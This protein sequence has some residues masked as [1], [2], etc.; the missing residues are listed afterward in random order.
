MEFFYAWNQLRALKYHETAL[1]NSKNTIFK[2]KKPY[3]CDFLAV[4]FY[5]F[6]I[7]AIDFH[8]KAPYRTVLKKKFSA[9]I[10]LKNPIFLVHIVELYLDVEKRATK[11]LAPAME[12]RQLKAG[13]ILARMKNDKTIKIA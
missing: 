6:C 10:C 3:F 2:S 9:K 12:I 13:L 11:P 8:T 7:L 4:R 5:D 1:K